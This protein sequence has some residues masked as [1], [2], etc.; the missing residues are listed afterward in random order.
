MGG[1]AALP[2]D[3]IVGTQV[4]DAI[5]PYEHMPVDAGWSYYYVITA[6]NDLTLAESIASNEV[7]AIPLLPDRTDGQVIW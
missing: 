2:P 7:S 1:N 4:S 6:V 3:Q 5:S